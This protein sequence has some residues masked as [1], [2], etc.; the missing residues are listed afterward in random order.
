[1]TNI[2]PVAG[3]P[4]QPALPR[5]AVR[6]AVVPTGPAPAHTAQTAQ[7]VAPVQPQEGGQPAG[8]QADAA[9]ELVERANR[10]LSQEFN[11]HMK[12][13]VDDSTDQLVVQVIDG[14]T[15]EVIRQFPPEEVLSRLQHLTDLKGLIFKGV[16]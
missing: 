3:Q 16:G 10:R 11:I 8:S 9:R 12:F 6:T 4:P 2:D 14:S 13:S 15:D 1:M 7:A 5:S